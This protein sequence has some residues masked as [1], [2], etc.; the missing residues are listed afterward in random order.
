VH[1]IVTAVA[2]ESLYQGWDNTRHS[3]VVVN[4]TD[5]NWLAGELDTV[6][7]HY[8]LPVIVMDYAAPAHRQT[9]RQLAQ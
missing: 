8:H 6:K 7:N 5:R 9:A 1:D 2:A 3:Y 4:E